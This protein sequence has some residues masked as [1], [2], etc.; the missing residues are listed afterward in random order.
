MEKI[1]L[2]TLISLIV[3]VVVVLKLR[4]VLGR[5]TGVAEA[6][7]G[8]IALDPRL[9]VTRAAAKNAAKLQH[10]DDG[11]DQPDEGVEVDLLYWLMPSLLTT[12]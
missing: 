1:D 2:F 3:A 4:S 11:H 10:Q 7:L 6:P 5:R 12:A 9:L 8:A